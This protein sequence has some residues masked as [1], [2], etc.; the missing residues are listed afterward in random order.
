MAIGMVGPQRRWRKRLGT[1]VNGSGSSL[2]CEQR[3]D[4]ALALWACK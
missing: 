4:G 3:G 1:T 2:A